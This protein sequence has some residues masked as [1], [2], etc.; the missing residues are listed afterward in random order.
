MEGEGTVGRH[1][2]SSLAGFPPKQSV[3]VD[4][5]PFHCTVDH[6]RSYRLGAGNVFR[7]CKEFNVA[8]CVQASTGK[9][10][11]YH[12][13]DMYAAYEK[14]AEWQLV[15]AALDCSRGFTVVRFTHIV[16]NSIVARDKQDKIDAGRSALIHT[17]GSLSYRI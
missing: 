5:A 4:I 15:H 1:L 3:S 12:T 2:V 11:R 8:Q 7:L 17:T 10:A 9:A 14:L 13:S 16:E 6:C